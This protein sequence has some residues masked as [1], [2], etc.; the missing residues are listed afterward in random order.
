MITVNEFISKINDRDLL[1][2]Y[3]VSGV[4]I[5]GSFLH[6]QQA[7]DIDIL[8]SNYQ[9]AEDL[10]SLR[11]ELEELSEMKVDLVLERFASPIVLFRAKKE[12]K[13]VA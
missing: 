5:F 10:I 13:Y 12:I 11:E 6:S 9:S 7:N 4:G 2:K 1:E 3:H 8:I